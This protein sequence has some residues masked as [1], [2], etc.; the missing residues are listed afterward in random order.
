MDLFWQIL[1]MT[2]IVVGLIGFFVGVGGEC[3]TPCTLSYRAQYGGKSHAPP[4]PDWVIPTGFSHERR[5]TPAVAADFTVRSGGDR[6]GDSGVFGAGSRRWDDAGA[7]KPAGYR[8]RD[9]EGMRGRDSRAGG[10]AAGISRGRPWRGAISARRAEQ[11]AVGAGVRPGAGPVPGT[12]WALNL[13]RAQGITQPC[14]K[15]R[16]TRR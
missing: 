6:S 4:A 3:S 13:G 5:D 7:G 12:L 11:T 1:G 2:L 15:C 10:L 16:P 14:R 8:G 9:G